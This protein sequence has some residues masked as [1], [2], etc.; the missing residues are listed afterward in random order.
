MMLD[1]NE[2]WKGF[3][4]NDIGKLFQYENDVGVIVESD[5]NMYYGLIK[6]K[7]YKIGVD[8]NSVDKD[9]IMK[10]NKFMCNPD[11]ISGIISKDFSRGDMILFE[12]QDVD[13]DL[14]YENSLVCYDYQNDVID[15]KGDGSHWEVRFIREMGLGRTEGGK[16]YV[17]EVLNLVVF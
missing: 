3:D 11:T 7:M 5:E 1:L 17:G 8:K 14:E 4:S 16:M 9:L 10:V 15:Y 13:G 6:N 12:Y 2:M